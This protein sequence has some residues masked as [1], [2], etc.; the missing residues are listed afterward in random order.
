MFGLLAVVTLLSL[1]TLGWTQD[2]QWNVSSGEWTVQGNWT[3]GAPTSTMEA[4]INGVGLEPSFAS[5]DGTSGS[6]GRLVVGY[7]NDIQGLLFLENNASLAIT[8][9]MLL[10]GLSPNSWGQC[11][12]NP[13]GS[14]LSVGGNLIV[15]DGGLGNF[16]NGGIVQVAGELIAGNSSTGAGSISSSGNS[17]FGSATIGLNGSA[18]F[19]QNGGQVTITNGLTLG[20]NSSSYGQYAPGGSGG[21]LQVGS[22]V[23]GQNLGSEGSFS[24]GSGSTANITN[25]LVVGDGGRGSVSHFFGQVTAGE[26]IL[27]MKGGSQAEYGLRDTGSLTTVNLVVGQGNPGTNVGEWGAGFSHGR[28]GDTIGQSTLN[29]SGNLTVG[30]GQPEGWTQDS[31]GYSIGKGTLNVHNLMVAAGTFAIK[32]AAAVVNV[33]G[34]ITVGPDGRFEAVVGTIINMTGANFFNHSTTMWNLWGL[35][36]L[37][38]IFSGGGTSWKTMEIGGKD[39]G[40]DI[41]GFDYNFHMTDLTVTGNNTRVSLQDAVNNGNRGIGNA[42]EALYVNSLHVNSGASLNLNNLPL[43]TYLSGGIHRVQAGEGALFG[44]GEIINS[45]LGSLPGIILPLLLD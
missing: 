33:S 1:A 41:Q 35:G 24:L 29:V 44:G 8:N 16:Y 43:Y 17:T 32:D 25:S 37:S 12:I 15:G 14:T 23:L 13:G 22:I 9:D 34:D 18:G 21:N 2:T 40:E 36:N 26:V 3:A 20:V 19:S 31:Y 4:W 5:L 6:A 39:Y 11:N 10:G 45:S 27:G 30:A 38:L 7:S 42:S 28:S